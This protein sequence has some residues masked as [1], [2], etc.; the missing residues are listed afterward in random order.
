MKQQSHIIKH[1]QPIR[2]MY[3]WQ[4]M[5]FIRLSKNSI[6]LITKEVNRINSSFFGN[7]VMSESTKPHYFHSSISV[8]PD[9][10][11]SSIGDA[12]VS[13]SEQKK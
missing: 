2:V 8:P 13:F 5:E 7:R 12:A 11:E 1:L 10:T 4:V 9:F 3:Q 6:F